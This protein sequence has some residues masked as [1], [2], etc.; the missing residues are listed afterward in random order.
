MHPKF[1]PIG[2]R[3]HDLQIM[4]VHSM[5]LRRLLYM[6]SPFNSINPFLLILQGT[7]LSFVVPSCE[8]ALSPWKQFSIEASITPVNDEHSQGDS[9]FLRDA[10]Q[11]L[12]NSHNYSALMHLTFVSFL[13][14]LSVVGW[15]RM[16]WFVVTMNQYLLLKSV[17]IQDRNIEIRQYCCNVWTMWG[18]NNRAFHY[19]STKYIPCP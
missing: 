18:I 4:T 19:Q 1:D 11:Q 14:L 13:S 17:T 10:S 8:P 12:Q 3:T 16:D 5:S 15:E 6:Y 9:C 7:I 2:V